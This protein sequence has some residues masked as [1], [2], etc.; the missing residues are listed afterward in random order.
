MA[1]ILLVGRLYD[2]SIEQ[3]RKTLELDPNFA[4]A[5]SELGEA[6]EQ[7]RMYNEAITEFQKAIEFSGG[8]TTYKCNLAHAYAVTGRTT[9]AL[10]ILDGL[11]NRSN[12]RPPGPCPGQP[13]SRATVAVAQLC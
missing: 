4:V 9:Q 8:N 5:H 3:S 1:H 2:E 13:D 12:Q 6:Y 10:E 7:K 11:K